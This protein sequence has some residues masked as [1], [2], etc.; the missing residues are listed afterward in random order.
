MKHS[1]ASNKGV[2]KRVFI[3]IRVN[4]LWHDPAPFKWWAAILLVV[5]KA[6]THFHLHL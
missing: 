4:F 6:I 1:S 2:G 5:A 3:G